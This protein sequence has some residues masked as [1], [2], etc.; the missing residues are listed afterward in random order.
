MLI[1]ARDENER[2]IAIIKVLQRHRFGPRSEKIDPDQLALMLERTSSKRSLAAGGRGGRQDASQPGTPVRRKRQI[3]RGALPKAFASRGGRRR[4]RRQV[5]PLL[6]QASGQ[7][8]RGR[9]GTARHDPGA[10][11][12]H[13]HAAGPNTHAADA[14]AR[15]RRLRRPNIQSK[16]AF[17]PRKHFDRGGGHRANTRTICRSIGEQDLWPAKTSNSTARRWPDW[18]GRTAFAPTTALRAV[19]PG[20]PK[21][22]RTSSSLTGNILRAGARSGPT[23]DQF[24]PAAWAYAR[25]D[26]LEQSRARLLT[27]PMSTSPTASTSVPPRIW[28]T[29]LDASRSMATAPC[30]ALAEG[31]R[32]YASRL[33]AGRTRGETSSTSRPR[34]RPRSPSRRAGEDLAASPRH[35]TRYPGARS[36]GAAGRPPSPRRTDPRGDEALVGGQQEEA[37]R[38]AVSGKSKARRGDPLR[39]SRWAGL[40]RYLDIGRIGKSTTTSSS[41]PAGPS[42]SGAESI[43]SPAW[44]RA[45]D[46]GPSTPR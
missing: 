40:T 16:T 3:N 13:R 31:N 17:R 12:G 35:R 44:T 22:S 34:T 1:A 33:S 7:A 24:R 10:L 19:V 4:S 28:P 2:L 20:M 37:R 25:N 38:A 6:Q 43:C 27:S 5:L 36:F 11:Q 39:A 46:I 26:N 21:G 9:L 42:R 30:K 15:W 23:E 45:D 14:A 41:A 32:G 18:S 8:R 29:S